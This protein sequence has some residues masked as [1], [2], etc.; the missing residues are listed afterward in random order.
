M[1]WFLV[2]LFPSILKIDF[3]FSRLF[4]IWCNSLRNMFVYYVFSVNKKHIHTRKKRYFVNHVH[5]LFGMYFI[6]LTYGLEYPLIKKVFFLYEKFIIYIVKTLTRMLVG[7]WNIY[8]L[9][10]CSTQSSHSNWCLCKI[11]ETQLCQCS[12]V[13][14][15]ILELNF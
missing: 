3:R 14:C 10:D 2:K 7:C 9:V 6:I 1:C 15:I 8:N 5:I 4:C 11:I 13:K 12:F